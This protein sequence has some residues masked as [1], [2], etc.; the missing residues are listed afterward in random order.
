MN[1][2]SW[3][4]LCIVVGLASNA[5]GMRVSRWVLQLVIQDDVTELESFEVKVQ[6][7]HVCPDCGGPMCGDGYTSVRHC[8]N[9]ETLYYWD[10]EP[11][12]EPVYCGK[13]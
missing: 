9:A 4:L 7:H 13:G 12:V 5:L 3:I 8:E 2:V 10:L 6:G 1:T 11:D